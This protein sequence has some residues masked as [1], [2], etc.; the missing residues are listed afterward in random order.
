MHDSWLAVSGDDDCFAAFGFRDRFREI[1]VG[2]ADGR[3]AH[4]R[5]RAPLQ[6]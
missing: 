3:F 2:V 6:G 1:L 5:L 4:G